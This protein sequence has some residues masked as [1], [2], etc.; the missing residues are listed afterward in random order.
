MRT[1]RTAWIVACGI[2]ATVPAFAET[3]TVTG[4]IVSV[5]CYLQS[6]NVGKA[7]FVC[8]IGDVKWEGNPPGLLTADGK[9]YELTGPLV[10][11]NNA[12]VVPHIGHKVT[13]SGEVTTHDGM[14]LLSATEL[15]MVSN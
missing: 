2:I 11:N 1:H 3:A 10:A 14:M 4:E 8:A 7:G 9:L 12:K 5:S 15:E 6:K 13:I